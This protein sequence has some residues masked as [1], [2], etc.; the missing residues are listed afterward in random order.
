MAPNVICVCR[1]VEIKESIKTLMYSIQQIDVKLERHEQR[2]RNI[3]EILKRAM[4]QLQKGQRLFEPMKGTFSRL[5]ERVGQIES[6]LISREAAVTD[7]QNKLAEALD[8]VLKWMTDNA[9]GHSRYIVG[10]G[11]VSEEDE[12][13]GHKIDDL[14]DNIKVRSSSKRHLF[15]EHTVY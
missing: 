3:G 8:A 9:N 13:L 1:N 11:D 14:S 12:D 15:P 4:V 5:D 10:K 7:Q 6:M 2:E